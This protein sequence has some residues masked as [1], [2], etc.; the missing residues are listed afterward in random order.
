MSPSSPRASAVGPTMDV[1]PWRALCGTLSRMT[2]APPRSCR[3]AVRRPWPHCS[4]V[5]GRLR[6]TAGSARR[7]PPPP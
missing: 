6:A 7:C 3:R 4:S 1:G 5:V 2:G